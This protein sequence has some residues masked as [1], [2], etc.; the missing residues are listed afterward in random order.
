MQMKE[1]QL[2]CAAFTIIS[3]I[4]A[5]ILL[6]LLLHPP[7]VRAER[8]LKTD[9]PYTIGLYHW[10]Y[11]GGM[12]IA[13]GAWEQ[14]INRTQVN[15]EAGA[16]YG[17]TPTMEIGASAVF[18]RMND[19]GEDGFSSADLHFKHQF[20]T[21]TPE[22]PDMAYD[23]RIR[24]PAG[25]RINYLG[26]GKPEIG[27]ALLFGWKGDRWTTSSRVGYV[28]TTSNRLGSRLE[29]GLAGRY[30]VAPLVNLLGEFYYDT[31]EKPGQPARLELG[32]GVS[33]ATNRN[34]VLDLMLVAGVTESVPDVAVR[35]GVT[36]KL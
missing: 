15:L 21:A 26:D 16:E 23:V 6:F 9:D 14:V 25:A 30:Q 7:P 22:F 28:Q 33:F 3:I 35:A 8:P 32:A 5:S 19:P 36:S 24:I 34:F 27:V 11:A 13:S 2:N 10:E 1:R 17:I 12:T 18:Y 31:N 29:A 20:A 4:V